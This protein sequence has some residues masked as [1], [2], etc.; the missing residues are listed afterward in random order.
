MKFIKITLPLSALILGFL[1]QCDSGPEEVT[2]EDRTTAI[3]TIVPGDFFILED[4]SDN[5]NDNTTEFAVSSENQIERST[6]LVFDY[7]KV[8]EFESTLTAEV[9][10]EESLNRSLEL[11]LGGEISTALS[12]ELRQILASSSDFDAVDR[13]RIV[14]ILNVAGAGLIVSNDGSEIRTGSFRQYTLRVD[15]NNQDRFTGLVGGIYT[16]ETSGNIVGFEPG[17]IPAE[18][19]NSTSPVTIQLPFVTTITAPIAQFELG[20]WTLQLVNTDTF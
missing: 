13:A 8:S 7:A 6:G 5:D 20:T 4:L 19:E 17:F 14:E 16:Y 2:L 1:T 18:F 11:V 12:A 3:E 15:S 10:A 9:D